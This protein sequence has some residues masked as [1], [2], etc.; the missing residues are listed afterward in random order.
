MAR[1][2][3]WTSRRTIS[4]F[5]KTGEQRTSTK[6]SID[7][8]AVGEGAAAIGCVLKSVEGEHRHVLHGEERDVQHSAFDVG[9]HPLG[10]LASAERVV[11]QEFLVRGD[12]EPIEVP[13]LGDVAVRIKGGAD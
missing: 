5:A 4:P 11:V 10:L 13:G 1:A 8:A 7:S 2:A 3:R 9:G 6:G 12:A